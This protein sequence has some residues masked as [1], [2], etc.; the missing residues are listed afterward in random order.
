MMFADLTKRLLSVFDGIRN[1]G[2]LTDEILE[3]SLKEIKISLIEADV[4]YIAVQSFVSNLQRKLSGQKVIS[5]MTPEQTVI[6]AVYEE[7]VLFLGRAQNDYNLAGIKT[8]LVA[9]IQG[10]GKITTS[11][12][13]AYLLKNK[14]NKQVLLISL[15]TYR[16]AA[17]EQLQK[18][19][20]RNNIHFFNEV[21]LKTDDPIAIAERAFYLRPKYDVMIYDAAGKTQ[22]DDRMMQELSKIKTIVNPNESLLVINGMGGQDSINAARSFHSNINYWVSVNK[23]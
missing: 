9:G 14:Y 11:A 17:Y 15:D 1:R 7:L 6:K 22:T 12:K 4:S 23:S 19:A 3:N 8:I 5:S 20:D 16:P 13:L 21:D 18:L 10:S 2:I